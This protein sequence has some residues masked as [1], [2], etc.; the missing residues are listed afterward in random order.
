MTVHRL[1]T[2]P[3]SEST[4]SVVAF[5]FALR[6]EN[7][8]TSQVTITDAQFRMIVFGAGAL[9]ALGIGSARF[10]GGVSL[11]PKPDKPA[12]IQSETDLRT[13]ATTSPS[14]YL[15]YLT[16]DAASA[17]VRTPSLDDM[18]RKLVFRIDEARHVLE[19]GA[20]PLEI[21]GLRLQA[22]RSGDTIV[23]DI[24]NTTSATLGYYV[25]TTPSPNINT[26][27]QSRP[28]P[29]NAM[30]IGRNSHETRVE[31]AYRDDMAIVVTHVETVELAP[32]QAF[33]V[34][35]VPPTMVGIDDRIARG[36][37]GPRGGEKCST[38]MSQ[39]VA[40]GL[41]R[42]EIAWRDLVDFYARHR[43]QTY[44]F[45]STYRAFTTDGQ[46]EIPAAP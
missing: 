43:C 27:S 46:R 6:R 25:A 30:V 21:A 34:N 8:C 2:P 33:Y 45:P 28:L 13:R 11:P 24:T 23:L 5:E 37:Q 3:A 10:C 19:L 22:Q 17:G 12:T 20:R 29:F 9:L 39:A 40:A 41:E 14:V 4:F 36:H 1:R 35:Q 42:G 7:V 38:V 18:T 16:K 31:C 26:C 32:L 44:Q 15:E